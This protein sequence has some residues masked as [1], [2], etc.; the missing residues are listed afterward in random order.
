MNKLKLAFNETIKHGKNRILVCVL[1]FFLL[2]GVLY[3]IYYPGEGGIVVALCA[4]VVLIVNY[5]TTL[6]KYR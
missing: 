2:G 3:E 4:I 6:N 1:L 5:L